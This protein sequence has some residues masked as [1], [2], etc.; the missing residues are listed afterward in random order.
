MRSPSR[1]L[2]VGLLAV[3]ACV[4][5]GLVLVQRLGTTYAD[6][7]EVAADSATLAVDAA[8]PLSSMT[9]NLVDFARVAETGIEEART[10]VDSAQLSIGQLGESAATDLAESVEGLA[11]VADSIAGVL[12]G[13]ERFIP[14][15]RRSAAEDLRQIADGLEPVPDDLR[16]VGAQLQQTASDLEDLDPT[17]AELA[18]TVA[19]LGDD[20][21]A[22]QPSIDEM[23]ATAAAL[24]ERVEDAEDRVHLDI[25]LARIVVVL[26]GAVFA[27]GL[28]LLD[29]SRRRSGADHA[30]TA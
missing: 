12:E 9:D 30:P 27:V 29:R 19:A 22:F 4:A 15:N 23:S 28:V 5:V 3:V 24:A 2:V 10:V 6:G 25:W 16:T 17:L 18:T 20:L 14:G 13:I 26:V 7:L 1:L 11:S 8:E 21:V